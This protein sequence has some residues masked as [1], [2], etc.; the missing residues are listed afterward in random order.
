MEISYTIDHSTT[1]VYVDADWAGTTLGDAPAGQPTLIFGYNAFDTFE[2]ALDRV[3][4]PG[5]IN[6]S[7]HGTEEPDTFAFDSVPSGDPD[8]HRFGF[9]GSFLDVFSDVMVNLSVDGAGDSDTADPTDSTGGVVATLNPGGGTVTGLGYA[10]TLTSS[11]NDQRQRARRRRGV[12]VRFGGRRYLHGPA[13]G[14]EFSGGRLQQQ[15]DGLYP[16]VRV[17]T[18]TADPT[19]PGCTTRPVTICSSPMAL[20][21]GRG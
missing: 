4:R 8:F 5:V 15:P 12:P 21:T 10:L 9:D 11:R 2:D 20:P 6:V 19:R 17:C 13:H 1:P 3:A 7:I 16:N 14:C 18:K